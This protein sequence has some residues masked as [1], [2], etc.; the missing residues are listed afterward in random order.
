MVCSTPTPAAR[1][2]AHTINRGTAS[3]RGYGWRWQ[4]LS[5]AIIRRDMGACQIRRPGCTHTATTTDHIRPKS[6]G[7]SDD[8]G[9]LR[10]A[11]LHCNS[12]KGDR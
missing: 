11:C 10:A 3:Q 4:Q 5:A 1:C 7:G 12:A 8:P 2:P 6:K 9:N